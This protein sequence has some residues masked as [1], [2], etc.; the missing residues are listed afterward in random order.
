[1]AP[2]RGLIYIRCRLNSPTKQKNFSFFHTVTEFFEFLVDISLVM[3]AFKDHYPQEIVFIHL[4]FNG[5]YL[6]TSQT[7]S[8]LVISLVT[9]SWL[10]VTVT[11]KLKYLK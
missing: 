6:L 7:S 11:L 4:S 8:R 9:C 10:S 3:I 2:P 5:A 1:M